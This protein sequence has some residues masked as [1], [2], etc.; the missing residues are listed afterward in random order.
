MVVHGRIARVMGEG[1]KH[2]PATRKQKEQLKFFGCTW[3]AQ[4]T[5]AEAA[6]AL[7]ECAKKFPQRM[8]EWLAQEDDKKDEREYRKTH[9]QHAQE[10][11][12]L[13]EIES[14][15]PL[16][17][18]MWQELYP[19]ITRKKVREATAYLNTSR[20][21]WENEG[22]SAGLIIETMKTLDPLLGEKRSRRSVTKHKSQGCLVLILA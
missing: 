22:R 5:Q 14:E 7:E 4:I 11:R 19:R 6:D 16:D 15:Y 21:G 12:E 9:P 13:R 18:G 8:Q 2:K 10:S 17:I 1:E 20:P 3:Q